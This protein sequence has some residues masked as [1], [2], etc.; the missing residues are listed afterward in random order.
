MAS[1]RKRPLDNGAPTVSSTHEVSPELRRL[2]NM[3]QFACL[4]QW[5]YIFSPAVK[6][7]AP[8]I[9]ELE[10]QC[11]SPHSTALQEIG[12]A[13]LKYL[14]SHRGLTHDLFDEYTR[15][16][17][18][19]KAPEKP[20][21]FGTD[22]V[23][24][25]FADFDV[26][27][28]IHVLYQMTQF[29]MMNAEKL[30]EKMTEQKDA[31]HD[32]TSW[33]IEPFGWDSNDDTY[34][35]LDD[36]RV[37]RLTELP[38]APAPSKPKRNTKKARAE[39][40]RASKRRRISAAA[41]N[42]GAEDTADDM[43]SEVHAEGAEVADD[44]LGSMKWECVAV[45]LD[46]LTQL[47]AAI[48]GKKD[49]NEKILH[50][51][52]VDHLLPIIEQQEEKRRKREREREKEL[53]N[54]AKLANAKRS[55]R[56]AG[57]QEQLRQEELLREEENKRRHEQEARRKEE[58]RLR[59]VERER[60]T[61]LASREKRHRE[62]ELRRIKHQEEL[63]HLSE[64]GRSV[65]AGPGRISERQ[66]AAEI[67][68]M[69]EAL[70]ELEQEQEEEWVFDCVC[71]LRGKVDDGQ[72][73]VS[74]ERCNTWQHSRCLGIDEA[75]AE[76]DDFH[77]VCDSCQR[78]AR[79]AEA[80]GRSPII[81]IKLNRPVV[82]KA[83]PPQTVAGTPELPGT[84]TD[85]GAQNAALLQPVVHSALEP[86]RADAR[87]GIPIKVDATSPLALNS[88]G[89]LGPEPISKPAEPSNGTHNPFSS[90][91]PDLSP[92]GQSPRKSHAY[93]TIYDE[94]SPT[95]RTGPV[96]KIG[97]Y[98][99]SIATNAPVLLPR[100]AHGSIGSRPS[101]IA[102]PS[103]PW[104]EGS[105]QPAGTQSQPNFSPLTPSSSM[106]ANEL[107]VFQQRTP[108]VA[109][110]PR[111]QHPQEDGRIGPR[112]QASSPLLPSHGGLSP[113]KQPSPKVSAEHGAS[114]GS[115]SP[116]PPIFPP[117]AALSPSAPKQ[118]LTPPVK[119]GSF[120]CR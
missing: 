68:K 73:S 108:S 101:G 22:E 78:R 19:S 97:E 91:H 113:T 45:T 76:Q 89:K 39:A 49:A 37:Y 17:Y 47:L 14:S 5:L 55:S 66:R 13:L 46:D 118:D 112:D 75:E 29:I 83:S 85:D 82:P 102:S 100:P 51:K 30:R 61:R 10:A 103:K 96:P 105:S 36:N 8:D 90:P 60:D 84:A 117:V 52:I 31:D 81:R 3:W 80:N 35:V 109:M 71:G 69:R 9:D 25:R 54:M 93:G 41:S 53:L 114:F 104:A 12:L 27:Q 63:A 58:Q 106:L 111:L 1:G 7:E 98:S 15:R 59:K 99:P 11:L 40:R 62:R 88:A 28:K 107:P 43:A 42:N 77:F 72:H 16:Q 50:N 38:P 64:D 67:E 24:A 44:G 120:T 2:R 32:Q 79:E 95:P 48:P 110:T 70:R 6:L 87:P 18:V 92:P 119:S 74:C 23:P 115:S 20:N 34:Y 21:P 57:R 26:T 116:T 4:C 86:P 56:I 65:S 94:N 33:R